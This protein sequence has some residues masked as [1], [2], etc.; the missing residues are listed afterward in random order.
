VFPFVFKSLEV[1]FNWSSFL[2]PL[3]FESNFGLPLVASLLATFAGLDEL[4]ELREYCED[5]TTHCFSIDLSSWLD[6]NNLLVEYEDTR[7][8]AHAISVTGVSLLGDICE[9]KSRPWGC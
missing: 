8:S 2:A 3:P 6:F 7:D 5:E 1:L 4:L 9:R